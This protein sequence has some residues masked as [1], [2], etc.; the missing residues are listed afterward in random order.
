M[1]RFP[2][3]ALDGS[4]AVRTA[5]RTAFHLL[6]PATAGERR[7]P[8]PAPAAR[9]VVSGLPVLWQPPHGRHA[10]GQP[11]TH[12]AV[13]THRRHPSPLSQTE[14]EPSGARPRDLSVS[15]AWRLDRAAQPGLEH[16]YYLHSNAWRLP[17]FG[18]RH[19]LVQPLRAQ[20]GTFQHHGN[21]LLFDCPRRRILLRPTRDLELRSGLAVHRGRFS[22]APEKARHLD[23]YGWTGPRPGQRF[24]RA[25]V[26]LPEVRTH[27]PRRLRQRGRSVGSAGWLLPLLQSPA[28]APGARLFGRRHGLVQPLRAQLGTFQHHGNRLLFDC[29]RRRI[30]LRP[31]RDLELRSGLAVH[32][33]RF[34][35]APEKARHLD[36]YGWTGP[37]PGQRFHRAPVALP[38]VRTH[39]PRRL[40]QRGRSVGS[41][42]WLLPLLQSPASAPGARL[43]HASRVVPAPAKKEKVMILM[44]ALPPNPRDLALFSSRM[45]GF[46]FSGLRS[47]LTMERLDRRIG[48]RR[49]ATRAPNQARN[50]WRPHGRLRVQPAS[51]SKDR[52]NFVQTMGSTTMCRE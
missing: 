43:P 27:L 50:G 30:L 32:R 14:L 35:G 42:G 3:S 46:F 37:R 5:R 31:T 28:S 34:S 17:L 16:R 19:G 24:H 15:A 9:R 44:G 52:Q 12:P 40:R 8:A 1:D 2:T 51:P 6:L 4:A 21:R 48:Q 18:R 36:Q 23:Q 49:D 38:E 20:L 26:A 22:G 41:A 7:K 10:G 29:P 33:G 25:P 45:D 13:V 39:L 47:C 11:Q